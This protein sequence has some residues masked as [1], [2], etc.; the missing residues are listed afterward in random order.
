MQEEQQTL[1]NNENWNEEDMVVNEA[2]WGI[3]EEVKPLT[4]LLKGK[5]TFYPF[6]TH[7]LC[8]F[9]IFFNVHPIHKKNFNMI[10]FK[11]FQWLKTV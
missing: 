8:L 2:N 4:E 10:L 5:E 3:E 11:L 6:C 7:P 9:N 1:I